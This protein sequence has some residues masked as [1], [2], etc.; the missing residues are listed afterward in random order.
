MCLRKKA[1]SG[2]QNHPSGRASGT[3]TSDLFFRPWSMSTIRSLLS[4]R[5][6]EGQYAGFNGRPLTIVLAVGQTST[7]KSYGAIDSLGQIC[8][9]AALIDG[10]SISSVE[11]ALICVNR[12]N[13]NLSWQWE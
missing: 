6:I 2:Q 4:S 1:I 5:L 11:A 3:L 7:N 12:L 13:D 10:R 8:Q 9:G